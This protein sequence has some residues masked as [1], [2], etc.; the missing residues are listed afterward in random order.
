MGVPLAKDRPETAAASATAIQ[1]SSPSF[2]PGEAIPPKHS[3]YADG[4]SPRLSWTPVANAKSY[5]LIAEDPDAKPITP[6]VHWVAWNIPAHVTT[7]PEGLQEQDRLTEPAGLMQGATSRGSVGYYGPRPP[8]GDPPH[9]YHF[10]VLALDTMLALPLGAGRD[11]VL[12]A[13]KGRV[14]AKGE[15]VGTYRQEVKPPK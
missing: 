7:L 15:L 12:A 9:R 5:V 10:Q 3:E 11:E 1:V 2:G 6:F 14:I 8:V 4:V 13:L